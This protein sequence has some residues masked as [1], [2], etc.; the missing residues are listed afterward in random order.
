MNAMKVRSQV[1]GD[2]RLQAG[3]REWEVQEESVPHGGHS[4][5]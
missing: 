2:R 5:D 3:M 1:L 4:T